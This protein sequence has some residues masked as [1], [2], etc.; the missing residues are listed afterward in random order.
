MSDKSFNLHL[1]PPFVQ[2]LAVVVVQRGA[3]NYCNN[4]LSIVT[5]WKTDAGPVNKRVIDWMPVKS[6]DPFILADQWKLRIPS[7]W[8]P[9]P[10]HPPQVMF[11]VFSILCAA[12]DTDTEFA[13]LGRRHY[14]RNWIPRLRI[15]C[16][17][18]HKSNGRQRQRRNGCNTIDNNL[19][20]LFKAFRSRDIHLIP[21]EF[22]VHVDNMVK[23][24]LLPLPLQ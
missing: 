4:P 9:P 5:K 24:L 14:T 12:R 22:T 8:H 13:R 2:R 10:P 21:I 6:M 15:T 17:T 7:L 16:S 11:S 20:T 18:C 3:L 23:V 19:K 1:A